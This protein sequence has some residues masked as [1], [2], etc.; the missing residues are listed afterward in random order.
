MILNATS[1][2]RVC[3]LVSLLNHQSRQFF[4]RT[5]Y[6]KQ[7]N[8]ITGAPLER[9]AR[10]N[11]PCS[12]PLIRTW[13]KHINCANTWRRANVFV[14][15]SL[16][17]RVSSDNNNYVHF[18]ENGRNHVKH[19]NAKISDLKD[20]KKQPLSF[21]VEAQRDRYYKGTGGF[22]TAHKQKRQR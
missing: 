9:R 22:H 15:S 20:S 12:P 10:G 5:F 4:K 1:K 7:I 16:F 17:G 19:N 6:L 11:C 8:V 21:Y 13:E 3:I 2:Y 18:F 14:L